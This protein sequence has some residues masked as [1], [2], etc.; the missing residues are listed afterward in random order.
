MAHNGDNLLD[1]DDVNNGYDH[2]AQNG[3]NGHHHHHENDDHRDHHLESTGAVLTPDKLQ[4]L[5]DGI[6]EQATLHAGDELF[7]HQQ[8][9]YHYQD[10]PLQQDAAV[11]SLLD[12][13]DGS[14]SRRFTIF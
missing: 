4:N 13:G 10:E 5:A 1:F 9:N 8:S 12:F 6:V 3:Q 2:G 7:S 11:G 14:Q